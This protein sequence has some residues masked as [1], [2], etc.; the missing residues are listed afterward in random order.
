MVK[1][2]F[3]RPNRSTTALLRAFAGYVLLPNLLFWVL[4]VEFEMLPRAVLNLDYLVV[5]MLA[6]YV[7]PVVATVLMA[8][9][10]VLDLFRSCGS[11]YYFS[12]R[13]AVA[14][15][16]FLRE[17]P[18]A[19]VAEWVLAILLTST[20]CS[21]GLIRIGGRG[22]QFR[23]KA[24]GVVILMFLSA[25]AVWGGNSSLR[26]RDDATT[27]NL[28]TSAGASLAKAV[29]LAAFEGR[30][31][32]PPTPVESA[33][34]KVGWFSDPRPSRNLVLVIV[35]SE[36]E[37]IDKHLREVLAR[38]FQGREVTSK[39]EVEEGTVAFRGATVP[40]EYREL[41]G[42]LAS[43]TAT[44]PENKLSDCLPARLSAAGWNT[45]YGHGYVPMM[46]RRS[47]WL[48]R[49]GFQKEY[50]HSSFRELGLHDCGNAFRGSCDEDLISWLGDYLVQH[51]GTRVFAHIT[52][53]NSHLP[54]TA[55]HNS[56]DALS[57]GTTH[58]VVEDVAT[59]N[60]VALLLRAESAVA[61]MATRPDLPETEFLI[62]GDHAPPF[63]Q[64]SRR[65]AFDQQVVRY[66]HLTPR[67]RAASR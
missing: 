25:L 49:I 18:I 67:S 1:L 6:P 56:A 30:S 26:F 61:R 17:L 51:S 62:V 46:F 28:C 58:A 57:C 2:F 39:Y 42:I 44:P 40:G 66:F 12:Q 53:L 4:G 41:C 52:T 32:L 20:I 13:D 21:H 5:G 14:A 33:T 34:R 29:W 3:V 65:D 9:V 45:I 31:S 55:D 23:H 15:L 60:L 50:F 38:P 16:L 37:P 35:E 24:L 36:G 43:A 64:R 10:L 27:P 48:P 19:R 47:E 7:G 59:C 22:F 11:V 8:V 63:L 54:V